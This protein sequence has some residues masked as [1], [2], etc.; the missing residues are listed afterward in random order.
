MAMGVGKAQAVV[1]DALHIQA[2]DNVEAA[3]FFRLLGLRVTSRRE[4]RT[5]VPVI[6]VEP[7][8]RTVTAGGWVNDEGDE[9]TE[10]LGEGLP[11]FDMTALMAWVTNADE[12]TAISALA[13]GK[14]APQR[15]TLKTWL[16]N[17]ERARRADRKQWE[18]EHQFLPGMGR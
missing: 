12:A 5:N 6:V 17:E 1:L 10:T 16:E 14:A 3:E 11:L 4:G 15:A 8:G 13:N 2:W 9:W 18:A 7:R